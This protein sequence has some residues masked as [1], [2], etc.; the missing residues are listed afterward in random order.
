MVPGRDV[1]THKIMALISEHSIVECGARIGEGCSIWHFTHIRSTAAIGSNTTIGSHC[2]ID[3]DVTIGSNCK[4]QSGCLIYH[5]AIIGDGVFV[6]P[7][8]RILNDKNPRAVDELGNKLSD[9]DWVCQGVIIEDMASIGAG[10]V[11]MPG[12]RIGRGAVIGAGSVVTK[13]VARGCTAYGE[14]A[15]ERERRNK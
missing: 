15:H 12:I 4:I 6:G 13:D 7:G 2:Y 10:S 5:P 14:A 1:E 11:I 9:S 8:V 3:S